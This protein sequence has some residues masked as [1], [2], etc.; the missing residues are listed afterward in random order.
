SEEFLHQLLKKAVAA[1]ASDIHLKVGQPPGVRVSGEIVYFKTEKLQPDDTQ[2]AARIIVGTRLDAAAF[3]E[4][5]EFD[6]S[7]TGAGI[8]RFRVNVYKQRGCYSVVMRAIPTD[9][10]SID[11][12]G[13]PQPIRDLA[14]RERGLVLV[15]GAAGNGKSTSLASMI[16]EVNTTRAR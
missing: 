13:L 2:A 1:G 6:G 3:A 10:P 15:V 14:Q 16:H 9:I 5:R 8:G 7:Y 12:L 11:D 4:L